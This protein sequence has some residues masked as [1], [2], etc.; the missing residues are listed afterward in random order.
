MSEAVLREECARRWLECFDEAD[1][2][3]AA[4]LLALVKLVPGNLLREEITTLLEQRLA[5]GATPIALFNKSERRLWKGRLHRLFKEKRMANG[6]GAGLKT[7]GAEGNAGPALV[8]RQR[9]V[10]EM[11]GSEG[12]IAN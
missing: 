12:V 5:D 10:D 3:N 2:P 6:K 9:S 8:P 7:T 1:R 11:I 4:K